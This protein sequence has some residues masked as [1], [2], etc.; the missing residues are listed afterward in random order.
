VHE[1]K[2]NW[3]RFRS[4]QQLTVAQ[5]NQLIEVC[6]LT[7]KGAALAGKTIAQLELLPGGLVNTNYRVH[8]NA[9]DWSVVL[10]LYVRDAQACAKEAALLRLVGKTVPVP[11]VLHMEPKGLEGFPPFA[12]LE[13][14]EGVIFRNLRRTKEQPAIAQA[15]ASIGAA[16]AAIA[17]RRFTK[18]GFFNADLEVGNWLLDG[19]DTIPRLI[20]L[21]LDSES[22]TTRVGSAFV[23][24]VHQFALNWA[25]RLSSV[26]AETQLVH[27]DFNASNIIVRFIKGSWRVAAVIDWEYSFSGSPL[28]D[29]GSVLRYERKARPL[30]EPHF[31]RACIE[32]GLELPDDW[33][34][35]ARAVDLCS[36]CEILSRPSLPAD[37]VEEVVELVKATVEDRDPE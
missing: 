6:A 28:W 1:E 20:D 2:A 5:A 14:V 29:V 30:V 4:H 13:Y 26:D 25:E 19:T 24:S 27:A 8:F 18:R 32:A 10:R 9:T 12:I 21:C 7:H 35:L 16:L 3:Q 37:V 31:S 34:R 36:L 23:E 15:A 33:R 17:N 22:L 11:E